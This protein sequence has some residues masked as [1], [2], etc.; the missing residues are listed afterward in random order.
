MPL[1]FLITP[2]VNN[3]QMTLFIYLINYVFI[4]KIVQ[5]YT[6]KKTNKSN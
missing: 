4:M 2:F 5:E 3:E 1:K 6:K